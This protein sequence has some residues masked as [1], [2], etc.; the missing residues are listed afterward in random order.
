MKNEVIMSSKQQQWIKKMGKEKIQTFQDYFAEFF[1][2]SLCL[3]SLEGEAL[4]VWSNS[5]LICHYMMKKN[6]ERCGQEREKII[7][8]VIDDKKVNIF[9]CYMG[10]TSFACPIFTDDDIVAM[11]LGGSICLKESKNKICNNNII[12][13]T[14]IMNKQKLKDMIKMLENIVDI[15]NIDKKTGA[16]SNLSIIDKKD[17]LFFLEHRVS[18]REI[19]VI[20]LIIMGLTNKEIAIRLN[21]SEKTVKAH[22]SNILKKLHVKDRMHLVILCTRNNI[23]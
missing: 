20:K 11:Y 7:K 8:K 12:K 19:E 18:V 22:V 23:F 10:L 17:E 9:T 3:L 5:C 1:N 4:T 2:I 14:T 16:E 15:W 13:H 21:I 6:Y